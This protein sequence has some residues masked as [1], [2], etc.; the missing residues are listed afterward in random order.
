MTGV[1]TA[2]QSQKSVRG[3]QQRKMQRMGTWTAKSW[4][5]VTGEVVKYSSSLQLVGVHHNPVV[6]GTVSPN[7]VHAHNLA[8]QCSL[9]PW[10]TFV[11]LPLPCMFCRWQATVRGQRLVPVLLACNI[12]ADEPGEYNITFSV[13][14]SSGLSASASRKLVIKAACPEGEKL[15]PDKVSQ[16][17]GL[18]ACNMQ[19]CL[20]DKKQ[21]SVVWEPQGRCCGNPSGAVEHAVSCCCALQVTCSQGGTCIAA[22]TSTTPTPGSPTS[23]SA[24]SSTSQAAVAA[25]AA[26][27]PN[28]PPQ[29]TLIDILGASPV[30]HVR[31]GQ[32]YTVCPDGVPPT[33]DVPCEPGVVAVDPDGLAPSD[34]ANGSTVLNLNSKVVVCPPAKC[35]SSGCSPSELQRHYLAAKG[36]KGCGIDTSAPEGTEFKVCQLDNHVW[37]LHGLTSCILY[38]LLAPLCQSFCSRNVL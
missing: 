34:G 16:Q 3:A 24:A 7:D 20:L 2:R 12:K 31:S 37:K 9:K 1:L 10:D 32:A 18:T 33:A 27:S 22:S 4:S 21:V 35:I 26:D 29:I 19:H 6:R 11:C 23:S 28:Q 13:T 14:S 30:V 8:A 36:L 25:T 5:V 17:G 15:C 38:T